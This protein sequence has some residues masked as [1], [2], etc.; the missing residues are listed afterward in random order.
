[1]V[2]KLVKTVD[3]RGFLI[4]TQMHQNHC[5]EDSSEYSPMN[6]D[7]LSDYST[8]FAMI[9]IL[10]RIVQEVHCLNAMPG[11]CLCTPISIPIFPLKRA[12]DQALNSFLQFPIRL[13]QSVCLFKYKPA[14]R[15]GYTKRLFTLRQKAPI[16][17]MDLRKCMRAANSQAYKMA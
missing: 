10:C 2:S 17:P 15:M 4:H 9:H 7:T 16:P 8:I 5:W 14:I 13:V 3:L 1:M 11:S 6:W 12:R